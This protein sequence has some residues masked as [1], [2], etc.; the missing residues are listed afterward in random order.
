MSTLVFFFGLR[1]GSL[2][3]RA[4]FFLLVMW[5]SIRNR[6]GKSE[7]LVVAAVVRLACRACAAAGHAT[8]GHATAAGLAALGRTRRALDLRGGPAQAGADLV[9]DD[10]DH[11]AL[12]T[13][14]SG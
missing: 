6:W 9:G 5:S 12:V 4:R 13:V 8:A 2:A 11:G 1:A 3:A 10:L 7:R 14:A